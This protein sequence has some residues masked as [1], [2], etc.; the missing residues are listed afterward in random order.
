MNSWVE[1]KTKQEQQ[2][3]SGNISMLLKRE[4]NQNKFSCKS[5]YDFGEVAYAVYGNSHMTPFR[6]ATKI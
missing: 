6:Q 3:S 1:N 5:A 4:R 2:K